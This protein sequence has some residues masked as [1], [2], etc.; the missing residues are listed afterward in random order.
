MHTQYCD[1]PLRAQLKNESNT[2]TDDIEKDNKGIEENPS[3]P[4]IR[5]MQMERTMLMRMVKN[6]KD[7]GDLGSTR[8]HASNRAA[9][10]NGLT[11]LRNCQA[12]LQE[13]LEPDH[14]S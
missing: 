1:S 4:V 11:E 13:I 12:V 3:S 10:N 5:K 9:K 6:S 14:V 8:V 7:Q 2:Q